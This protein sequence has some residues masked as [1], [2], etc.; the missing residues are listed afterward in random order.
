MLQTPAV[1]Y[2]HNNYGDSTVKTV[3]PVIIANRHD[4]I[5]FSHRAALSTCM[6]LI[7]T[8]GVLCSEGEAWLYIGVY[9]VRLFKNTYIHRA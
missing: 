5:V 1:L 7:I 3:L 8:H 2:S 9:T 4:L 6:C